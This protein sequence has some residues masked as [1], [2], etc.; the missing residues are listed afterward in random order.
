MPSTRR[1]RRGKKP[2]PGRSVDMTSAEISRYP[3]RVVL[4]AFMI[5]GHPDVV[6]NGQGDQ[7]AA[8]NA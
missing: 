8:L 7:E 1:I 3:V 5:L 4:S 6:L 2:T